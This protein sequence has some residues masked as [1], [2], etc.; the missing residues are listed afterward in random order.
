[1]H[2]AS[3]YENETA[4]IMTVIIASRCRRFAIYN[5]HV[6]KIAYDVISVDNKR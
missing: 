2:Y 3:D 4:I 6:C 5:V 1:M